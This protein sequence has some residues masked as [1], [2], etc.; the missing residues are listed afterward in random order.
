MFGP[1]YA[2][3]NRCTKTRA[4][5]QMEWSGNFAEDGRRSGSLHGGEAVPPFLRRRLQ[6][7]SAACRDFALTGASA[8]QTVGFCW[9][10][11]GV[12]IAQLKD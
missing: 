6:G 1:C 9:G 5:E 2:S 10:G 8:N 12:A 7:C 11:T 3:I 4:T